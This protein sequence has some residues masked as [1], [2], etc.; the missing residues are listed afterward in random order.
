M[1][2]NVIEIQRYQSR[3]RK[4]CRS[5]QHQDMWLFTCKDGRSW[6]NITG[7]QASILL[8]NPIEPRTKVHT[9]THTMTAEYVIGMFKR[10]QQRKD[11]N[12]N[13]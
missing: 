7:S 11:D 13:N 6:F 4:I 3:G 12:E 10:Q 8:S 2:S 9:A 5:N 1:P